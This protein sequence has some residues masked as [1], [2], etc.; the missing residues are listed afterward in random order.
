MLADQPRGNL[1]D[2]FEARPPHQR[3]VAEHPQVVC[4]CFRLGEYFGGH[5]ANG[6]Q[7]MA[8]KLRENSVCFT[9]P[10]RRLHLTKS[11]ANGRS[12]TDMTLATHRRPLWQLFLVPAL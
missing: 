12:M 1:L 3:P 7:N 9:S 2:E 6:Y 10:T 8:V 4:G 5:L 11:S